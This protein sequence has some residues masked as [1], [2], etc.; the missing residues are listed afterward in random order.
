MTSVIS[1]LVFHGARIVGIKIGQIG[2]YAIN[3]I[4]IRTHPARQSG[5]AYEKAMPTPTVGA[6]L[7]DKFATLHCTRAMAYRLKTSSLDGIGTF[8]SR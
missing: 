6:Q 8:W 2:E 5:T 4:V 3:L 1:V 7:P